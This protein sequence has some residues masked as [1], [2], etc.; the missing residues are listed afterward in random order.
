MTASDSETVI[1]VSRSEK[2]AEKVFLTSIVACR[3][4]AG[5]CFY[6]ISDPGDAAFTDSR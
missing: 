3:K 5:L 1:S 4:S 6:R 2:L